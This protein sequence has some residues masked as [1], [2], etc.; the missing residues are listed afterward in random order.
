MNGLATI[1]ASNLPATAIFELSPRRPAAA[2][3]RMSDAEAVLAGVG[4]PPR[5]GE[6]RPI[7][8]L[9]PEVLAR[10]GLEAPGATIDVVA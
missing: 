1:V 8:A 4:H 9:L 7:G 2:I 6:V 10:Y 5:V 3:M